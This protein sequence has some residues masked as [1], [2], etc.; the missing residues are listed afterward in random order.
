MPRESIA[1]FFPLCVWKWDAGDGRQIS[2]NN[3]D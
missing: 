3:P 1:D 2:A